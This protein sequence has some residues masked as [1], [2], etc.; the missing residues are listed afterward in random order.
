MK[1]QL[2]T[3]IAALAAFATQALA[4]GSLTPPGAP[5]PT[6]KTLDELST[7]VAEVEARIDL[8][9]VAGDASYHHII[10]QSGSY[11][12]SGNLEVTKTNGIKISAPGAMLDLNGFT[13]ERVSGSEGNGVTIDEDGDGVTVK[14]GHIPGPFAYSCSGVLASGC[15]YDRLTV[16]GCSWVGISAGGSSSIMGCVAYL[17]GSHGIFASTSSSIAQC[18]AFNNGGDGVYSGTGSVIR[19]CTVYSNDGAYGLYAGNANRVVDCVSYDNTGS[20]MFGGSGSS[21]KGCSVYANDGAYGLR[22]YLGSQIRDCTVYKN[23]SKTSSSY[24]IYLTGDGLISD[25]TLNGN[26]HTNSPGTSTQGIG[27]YAGSGSTVKACNVTDNEGDGIWVVDNCL[28]LDNH[29]HGNGYG[30]A[31]AGI[32]VTGDNNR[33]DGNT[34]TD[35][36]WGIDVDGTGNIIVRNS[37][38]GNN[39]DGDIFNLNFDGY[40]IEAGNDMGTIQTT[41]V[42]AGPWDNFHFSWLTD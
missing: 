27:V 9:T 24:G 35:N 4:Q 1:K 18:K 41:P 14:N 5:A 6:M 32:H 39:A 26:S 17:N 13:I 16:S 42:G 25:C 37:A 21:F 34:V 31:G 15:T 7:Q 40:S 28:V 20:G 23:R 12:L 19:D 8:S 2:M 38:H 3:T 11:Y 36:D 30:A 29:C 33:I 10:N 22:A